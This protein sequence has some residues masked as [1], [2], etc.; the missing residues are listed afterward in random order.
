[1]VTLSGFGDE[2]SA[3]LDLGFFFP[4]AHVRPEEAA[5]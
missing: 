5:G 1:M 4:G 3:D 2:I